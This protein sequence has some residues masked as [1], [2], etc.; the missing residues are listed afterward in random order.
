MLWN[1]L[2]FQLLAT[3]WLE[4]E[5]PMRTRSDGRDAGPMPALSS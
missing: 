3:G 4:V 1:E 2:Q 5:A